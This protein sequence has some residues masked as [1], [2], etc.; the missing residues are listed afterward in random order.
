M[1]IPTANPM[2][3]RS[4]AGSCILEVTTR[5]S[6]LSQWSDR[7]VA[8]SL[9]FKLWLADGAVDPNANEARGVPRL[10]AEGDGTVLQSITRYIQIRTRQT[11]AVPALGGLSSNNSSSSDSSSDDPSNSDSSSTRTSAYP[12]EFEYP[13]PL[14]YLQLCDLNTVLTQYEQTVVTLPPIAPEQ[15]SENVILLQP[16][17][18]N[19]VDPSTNVIRS[20]RKLRKRMRL[21]ASAAATALAAVGLTTALWSRESTLQE[22]ATADNVTI[23]ADVSEPETVQLLE[24]A[25]A[26]DISPDS[27]LDTSSNALPDSSPNFSSNSSPNLPLSDDETQS[28]KALFEDTQPDVSSNISSGQTAQSLSR[29]QVGLGDNSALPSTDESATLAPSAPQTLTAAP[30]PT[31]TEQ[32]LAQ[33]QTEILPTTPSPAIAEFGAS[34][35]AEQSEEVPRIEMLEET[36]SAADINSAEGEAVLGSD[37]NDSARSTAIAVPNDLPPAELALQSMPIVSQVQTYF[38][39]RW[40][41]GSEGI[42][43]Y[44]LRLSDTGDILSFTAFSEAAEQQRERILPSTARPS[45]ATSS[46]S[47]SLILRVILSDD[48]TVQV[49][50]TR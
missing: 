32:D 19:R 16:V 35:L 9:T 13:Q 27:S 37:P 2:K 46:E 10:V 20:P 29:T 3:Q 18:D 5:P 14:S 17:R 24:Q 6:A 39:Q 49:I 43:L 25:Q 45:F 23:R 44:E 33:N 38:Q 28:A 15:L 7:L 30:S 40:Q 11:L 31:S 34:R 4:T 26:D 50:E 41:G 42:L 1:A 47:D 21:W 22:V 12:P 48:G 8:D 36:T